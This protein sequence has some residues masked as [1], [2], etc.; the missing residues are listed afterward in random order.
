[1]HR[2]TRRRRARPDTF[3]AVAAA[4]ALLGV[5]ALAACSGDV[6]TTPA[7]A[8]ADPIHAH[9][10][11]LNPADGALYIATHTGLFRMERG[12]DDAAR[13]GDRRQ[14]TMGFTIAAADHFL[15]SGH[16]DLREGL[17]P[18]LGL[19]GSRDRGRSWEP[20]SLLGEADFHALR[21]TGTFIHGYDAS[22]GRLMISEDGGRTWRVRR[23]PPLLDLVVDPD[24]PSR[25]VAA[26]E[27]GLIVS[28]DDGRG[29]RPLD[30][31]PGLLAW[32]RRDALYALSL[33]GELRVSRDGGAS[34]ARAGRVGGRPEAMT[35]P[36]A[37][38]L[39][40]A[41]EHGALRSSADGG[42]SWADGAWAGS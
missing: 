7:G 41:L 39:I 40:V 36:A 6:E 27:R 12:S 32:P 29:W 11:G 20:I 37:D 2:P 34:W 4:L 18:L 15:G 33:D 13:V 14:D 9:G 16:P 26:S 24:D 19:I 5:L 38:R 10:L 3:R 22:G 31:P 28:E 23:P 35:V 42:R 17:P 30:G 21:A 8:D 1:M 25:I